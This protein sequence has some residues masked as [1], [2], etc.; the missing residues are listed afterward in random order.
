MFWHSLLVGGECLGA[1]IKTVLRSDIRCRTIANRDRPTIVMRWRDAAGFER[2]FAQLRGGR[3]GPLCAR[4]GVPTHSGSTPSASARRPWRDV[5]AQRV[6]RRCD[7]PVSTCGASHVSV[8]A[9]DGSVCG[10]PGWPPPR[11]ASCWPWRSAAATAAS[12]RPD[13]PSRGQSRSPARSIARRACPRERDESLRGRTLP[14][15][16]MA[17]CPDVYRVAHVRAFPARA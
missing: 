4:P 12:R 14:L 5:R 15:V 16:S 3:V 1:R 2:L 6:S 9:M 8:A 10:R 11:S 13:A 7:L 17:P